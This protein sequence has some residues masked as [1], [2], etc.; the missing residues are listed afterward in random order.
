[1]GC[2]KKIEFSNGIQSGCSEVDWKK[3]D[4]TLGNVHDELAVKLGPRSFALRIPSD[5]DQ[6]CCGLEQLD[7]VRPRLQAAGSAMGTGRER[8]LRHM[9]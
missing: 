6:I 9:L 1:L 8:R 3:P 5:V 7:I 4:I 2:N